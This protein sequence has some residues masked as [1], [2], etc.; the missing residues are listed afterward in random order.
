MISFEPLTVFRLK[1][2]LGRLDDKT[3]QQFVDSGVDKNQYEDVAELLVQG[4]VKPLSFCVVYKNQCEA[5][6][7]IVSPAKGNVTLQMLRGVNSNKVMLSVC[8]KTKHET[9]PAV[10]RDYLSATAW[11]ANDD[12]I[13]I[14]WMERHIGMTKYLLLE[15]YANGNDYRIYHKITGN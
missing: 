2:L 12:E 5:A 6:V 14:R 7:I 9:I 4:V 3:K 13:A 8:K 10:Y 15:K 1:Q 11:V